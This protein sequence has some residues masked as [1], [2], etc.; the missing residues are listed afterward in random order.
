LPSDFS[1]KDSKLLC[2]F[3]IASSSFF[4]LSYYSSKAFLSDVS[5]SSVG[6]AVI[7]IYEGLCCFYSFIGTRIFYFLF[8]FAEIN[9]FG[10]IILKSALM[11][12]ILSPF[13]P[14]IYILILI[15]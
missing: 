1:I 8:D 12:R 14:Y 4:S 5:N 7:N 6:S 2:L 15:F 3:E 11:P 10:E 13:S 9:D